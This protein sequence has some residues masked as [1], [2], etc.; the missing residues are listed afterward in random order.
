MNETN[1]SKPT[2]QRV[3]INILLTADLS[4]SACSASKYLIDT[5]RKVKSWLGVD[6][7]CVY[8]LPLSDS[9]VFYRGRRQ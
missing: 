7:Q 6:H 4:Y 8:E 5:S 9:Y 3:Y 1:E 2:T